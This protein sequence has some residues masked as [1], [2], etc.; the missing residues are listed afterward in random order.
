[1]GL[2]QKNKIEDEIQDDLSCCC[3]LCYLRAYLGY[4]IFKMDLGNYTSNLFKVLTK[5]F[6][7]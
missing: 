3:F 4:R 1:M 2:C 6:L 5:Y 7:N